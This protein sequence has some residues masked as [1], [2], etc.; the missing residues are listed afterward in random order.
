MGNPNE[1]S[2]EKK[3]LADKLMAVILLETSKSYDKMDGDLVSECVSFLMELE[4]KDRLTREEIAEKIS[5][6]PF[7]GKI[8]AI[9]SHAKK[10]LRAKRLAVIAA[11]L[12]VLFALFG[13]FAVSSGDEHSELLRKMG[14]AFFDLLDQGPL[15]LDGITIYGSGETRTYDSIDELCN[16][17]EISILYPAWL[18]ENEKIVKVWYSLN[19]LDEE[20]IFECDNPYHGIS[21]KIGKELTEEIKNNLTKKVISG[22][23]VYYERIDS[24]VQ[25]NFVY[26]NNL[27]FVNTDTEE[28]LFRIIENL[29]EIN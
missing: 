7:K 22:R 1:M 28:N 12:A 18:P 4:E 20:Y 23:A 14:E 8:A 9:G 17:E 25:A 2:V 21:I 15:E 27:Y 13:T 3:N 26:K 10:K 19:E 6:I 24:I 5:K 11:I 16:A 29:E